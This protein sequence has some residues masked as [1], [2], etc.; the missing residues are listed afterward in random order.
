MKMAAVTIRNLPDEAHRN[1]KQRA[2]AKGRSTEA[3]MRAILIEAATPEE[4]MNLAAALTDFGK[5]YRKE[6]SQI[7]FD[8]LRDQSEIEPAVFE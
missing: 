7:D 5:R 2:K 3:E 1:L 6:L 4:S 8:S